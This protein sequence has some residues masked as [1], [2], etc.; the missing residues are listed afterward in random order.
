M[1]DNA[2]YNNIMSLTASDAIKLKEAERTLITG[3]TFE[4]VTD[5][6]FVNCTDT[7]IYG[8]TGDEALEELNV[9]DSCFAE[10]SDEQYVPLC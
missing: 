8:N 7:A 5:L 9:V 4:D 2:F 6:R 3:N 10:S 1:L